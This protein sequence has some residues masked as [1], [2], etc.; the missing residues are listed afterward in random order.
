MIIIMVSSYIAHIQCSVRFTHITPDHCT[1]SFMYHCNSFFEHTALAAISA[2]WGRA[3]YL[4]VTE[5]PHNTDFH[6][7]I[8]KK[9]VF[10]FFNRRDRLCRHSFDKNSLTKK[11]LLASMNRN[12]QYHQ[13]SNIYNEGLLENVTCISDTFYARF[14]LFE[15]AHA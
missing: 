3:R 11:I 9:H 1:C 4:S 7:W 2:V 13:I 12:R 5:A 15:Y 10:C 14:Y 6:T 8:G